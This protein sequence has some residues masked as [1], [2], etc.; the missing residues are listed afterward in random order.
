M[1]NNDY[2]TSDGTIMYGALISLDQLSQGS[3]ENIIIRRVK[4]LND[5]N[6]M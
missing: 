1:E 6:I 2:K 4:S 3:E 5:F